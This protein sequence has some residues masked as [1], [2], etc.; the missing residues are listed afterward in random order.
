MVNSTIYR[1][2]CGDCEGFEV[3]GSSSPNTIQPLVNLLRKNLHTLALPCRLASLVASFQADIEK[4]GDIP[5]RRFCDAVET[6]G[7]YPHA[8]TASLCPIPDC[9]TPRNQS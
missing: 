1:F 7:I 5:G 6:F 2:H 8:S 4:H 3:G 9:F